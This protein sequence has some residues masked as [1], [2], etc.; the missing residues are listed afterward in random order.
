MGLEP[1][2][3]PGLKS[4]DW[5]ILGKEHRLSLPLSHCHTVTVMEVAPTGPQLDMKQ[6]ARVPEFTT[7]CVIDMPPDGINPKLGGGLV[8][9]PC[10]N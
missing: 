8:P 9:D 6:G 5:A 1:N 10:G 7:E 2:P 3:K 4:A